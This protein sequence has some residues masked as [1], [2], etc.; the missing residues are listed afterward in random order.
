MVSSDAAS[1]KSSVW[2]ALLI[3]VC[4]FSVYSITLS[5]NYLGY[6]G[7][8]I[9]QAQSLL[10]SELMQGRAGMLDAF[11]YVPFVAIDELLRE[12]GA[13]PSFHGLVPNFA[14]PFF[15]AATVV[16]VFLCASELFSRAGA[17]AVALVF[18]FGTMAWPY[19]K[20]GMELSLTLATAAAFWGYVKL[21]ANQSEW[22]YPILAA[23]LS[24]ML[25]TKVQAPLVIVLFLIVIGKDWIGGAIP[26]IRVGKAIACSVFAGAALGIFISGNIARYDRVLMS[27]SYGLG[28]ETA[29]PTATG[30]LMH[31]ASYVISPGK[32]FL[33][34]NLPLL[35]AIAAWP[36]FLRAHRWYGGVL[37]V[38]VLPQILFHAFFRTWIDETWGPRRLLSL[39]PL[40]IVP[41]GAIWDSRERG[42]WGRWAVRGVIALAVL[43]Q[44]VA[45]SMNYA[46]YIYSLRPYDLGTQQN[47]VW[48]LKL[49]QPNFQAHLLAS[50]IAR[51]FGGE[52]APMPVDADAV[53]RDPENEI[54][55]WN[56][57]EAASAE[58]ATGETI[59]V[60]VS[61]YDRR[62]DFWW[63]A[64]AANE[65][66]WTWWR[67]RSFYLVLLLA[68]M[69]AASLAALAM[70]SRRE[71]RLVQAAG[72]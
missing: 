5:A 38:I 71:R 45:V 22:G 58:S 24:L 19:S 69:G 53:A 41:I 10:R 55:P 4:S 65:P 34:F 21:R 27:T 31:L 33:L 39:V 15:T 8:T 72:A 52:S 36:R 42:V 51:F 56:R 46:S 13:F 48:N 67:D 14:L 47:M 40:L 6:E 66:D 7:E 9:G 12:R 3:F 63:V 37:L 25:L 64:Q 43:F 29:P 26:K 57:S 70:I 16:L 20:M 60:D 17:I 18:A 62:L 54:L 44:I 32:S 49:S 30:Y 11:F 59:L 1:A 28:W 50:C 61:E 35:I 23:G 2:T 68:A